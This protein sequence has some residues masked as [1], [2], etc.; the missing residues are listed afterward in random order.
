EEQ[1]TDTG[2]AA[3]GTPGAETASEP[4]P[5]PP[6]DA[7]ADADTDVDLDE[8]TVEVIEELDDGDGADREAV[9]STVAERH[10]FDPDEVAGALEDAMMSGRAY[11][12]SDG[13]LKAI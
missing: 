10:G 8:V 13:R 7:D 5:E 1:S 11:E 12:P 6:A 9:V 2:D 3:A 4:E